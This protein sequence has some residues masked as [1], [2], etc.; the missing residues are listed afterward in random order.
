MVLTRPRFAATPPLCR[1]RLQR[2]AA[3]NYFRNFLLTF[4]LQLVSQIERLS[5]ATTGKPAKVALVAAM[6]KLL[7]ILYAMLKTKTVWRPPCPAA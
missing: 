1:V 3:R 5:S 4:E 7:L 2:L 6:H